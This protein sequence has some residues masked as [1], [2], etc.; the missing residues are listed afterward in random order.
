ML[1]YEISKGRNS[2]RDI[3]A[4]VIE[5]KENTN[6][7]VPISA[8]C[9]LKNSKILEALAKLDAGTSFAEVAKTYSEDKA[10]SGGDLGWQTRGSMVG[11]FQ[12]AA[13]AAPLNKYTQ[14]IKTQFGYH[15]IL[16]EDRQ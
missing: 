15:I 4:R 7:S 2:L 3:G 6:L 5:P 16:V 14:P 13:F 10:R 9:A 8:T 1:N 11:A 12:D